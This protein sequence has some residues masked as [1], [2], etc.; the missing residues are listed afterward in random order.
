[1]GVP[2]YASAIS[3][4]LPYKASK[5]GFVWIGYLFYGWGDSGQWPNIKINGCNFFGGYESTHAQGNAVLI[6]VSKDDIVTISDIQGI[7]AK[8]IPSK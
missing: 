4:N 1:M 5:S 8:F 2:D 6:P 7:Y 3:I